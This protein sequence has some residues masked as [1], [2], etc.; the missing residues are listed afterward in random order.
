MRLR[1]YRA[2]KKRFRGA[3]TLCPHRRTTRAPPVDA[4]YTQSTTLAHRGQRQGS[5]SQPRA[6]PGRAAASRATHTH[7]PR[8]RQPW[9]HKSPILEGRKVQC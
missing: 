8:R 2:V 7:P 5:A 3:G 9:S 4:R 6:R 1:K